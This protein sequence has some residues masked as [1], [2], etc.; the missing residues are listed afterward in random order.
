[1]QSREVVDGVENGVDVVK[2]V[3][4]GDAE[5]EVEAVMVVLVGNPV[6]HGPFVTST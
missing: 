5:T 4:M 6:G 2:A 3:V 1:M